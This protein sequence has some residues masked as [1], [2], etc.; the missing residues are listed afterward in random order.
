MCH[1]ADCG[2]EQ[3]FHHASYRGWHH[4]HGCCGPGYARRTFPTREEI[5]EELEEYL[6]QLR[7]E[8]KV[9]EERI[10]E[11]SKES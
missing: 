11:L 7:A 9:V 6:K 3:H 8:A 1:Q 2:Y 10:A 5:T 4:P